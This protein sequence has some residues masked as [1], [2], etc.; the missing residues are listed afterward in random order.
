MKARLLLPSALLS[1]FA[2]ACSGDDASTDGGVTSDGGSANNNTGTD[3]GV[4]DGG[5]L[6]LAENFYEFESRFAPG[7]SS[8]AYNGQVH[9][10]VLFNDMKAYMG[11]LTARIDDGDFTP[12]PGDVRAALE[13][14]IDFDPE[15]AG[16]E[17]PRLETDP[18]TLQETY[19]D[20]GSANI[21]GKIAGN[22]AA[23]QSKDWNTEGFVGW[24]QDGVLSPESL[25]RV[26][27]DEL[28]ALAVER[29]NGNIPLDP[30]GNPMPNVFTS[31]TG[32]DYQQL[33][34]KFLRGSVA[35]SQG[36][37]DYLDDD[38]EGKG[39]LTDNTM[40]SGDSAYTAMEHAWDEGF[41]YF[42]G[43]RNYADYTDEEIAGRGGRE[44]W[45]LGYHDTNGDGRIDLSRE[46]NFN[47]STNAAKRDLGANVMTD[48]TRD[49]IEAF[50]QGRRII[51]EAGGEL[52]ATQRSELE[53]VRDQAVGAWERTIAA[54]AI[55]YINEVLQDMNDFGTDDYSFGDHAKHWGE[56][57]G[58]MFAF[59]FNPRSDV[60]ETDFARIHTLVGQRPV[61]VAGAEADAYRQALLEARGILGTSFGFD[62]Q[63]LGD[64]NGENGW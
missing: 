42:G 64:D 16:T 19:G 5:G 61:L 12:G 47:A 57:K 37:D 1:A 58:F 35:F 52:S 18:P 44:G 23:G 36:A 39:I 2:L 34:M 7:E 25:V 27:V 29:A 31:S 11:G 40:A 6:Q 32:L 55:H 21:V 28:D 26:W 50:Y 51:T 8:V 56:M 54:T 3:G 38:T 10:L 63:N 62:M 13:F 4:T 41:G 15:T 53:T 33:I 49:A 48:F 17:P 45:S 14:Y 30:N 20:I 59:Q 24:E 22:D 43:A 60:S 46:M 9:R